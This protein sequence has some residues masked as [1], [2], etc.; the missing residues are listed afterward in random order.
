MKTNNTLYSIKLL[1]IQDILQSQYIY[2][3]IFFNTLFQD[4]YSYLSPPNISLLS[5]KHHYQ[6]MI[7]VYI[8]Q[9]FIY[10]PQIIVT[11]DP[12]YNTNKY[13]HQSSQVPLIIPQLHGLNSPS[14]FI[15][16]YCNEIPILLIEMPYCKSCKLFSFLCN[17]KMD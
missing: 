1:L 4:Q 13:N 14:L 15:N 2:K 3:L 5:L 17:A 9:L 8:P 11:F 10:P 16:E 6:N 12:K 7:Y